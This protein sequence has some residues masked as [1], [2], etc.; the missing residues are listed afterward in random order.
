MSKPRTFQE[1]ATKAHDV[2][3]TI[4]SRR[5]KSSSLPDS[6][7]DKSEFKKNPKSSKSSKKESMAASTGNWFESPK[8]PSMN[9]KSGFSKDTEEAS[10]V[11]GITG[12]EIPL[13]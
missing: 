12:E 5:S 8:S 9:K 13:P 4:T 11:K 7:K 10:Y 1:L 3:M 6:G 2:E